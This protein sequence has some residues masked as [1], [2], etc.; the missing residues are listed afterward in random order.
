MHPAA[1]KEM[2]QLIDRMYNGGGKPQPVEWVTITL[3]EGV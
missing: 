3:P 1:A 2:R